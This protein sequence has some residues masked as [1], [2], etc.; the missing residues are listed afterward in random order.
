[1]A[2]ITIP[3]SISFQVFVFLAAVCHGRA[4]NTQEAVFKKNRTSPA[5]LHHP[6]CKVSWDIFHEQTEH[7]DR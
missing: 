7:G 2:V 6:S 5:M 1:M 3:H 4:G